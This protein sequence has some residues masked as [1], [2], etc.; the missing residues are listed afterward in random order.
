[1]SFGG[2]HLGRLREVWEAH[3][4][5]VRLAA[6]AIVVQRQ[7][8][9][10]EPRLAQQ[11]AQLARRLVH[12]DAPDL[13]REPDVVRAAVVAGEVRAD[14]VAQVHALADV[15]RQL[16]H[17]VEAV[18][19]GPFGQ[20]LERVGSELRRKARRLEEPAHRGRDLLDVALAV[21]RLHEAPD[22]ARVA[23]RGMAAGSRGGGR[24]DRF[25][26]PVPRDHRVQ[27]VPHRFG[28]EAARQA[29][30]AQHVRAEGDL[31]AAE[32]VLEE[33]VVEAR[34]VGDEELALEPLQHVARDLG[35]G[36][37]AAH[38]RVGDAGEDLDVLG[39]GALGIHQ[40]G[41]FVHELAAGHAH[42]A[43]LGDAIARRRR[44]GGLQVDERDGGCEH[45]AARARAARRHGA[46]PKRSMRKSTI[47]ATRGE[48][49]RPCG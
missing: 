19:A 29:H 30:G 43:D 9:L 36:G 13:A 6:Q 37:R 49:W 28:I 4:A 44:A 22:R 18:D 23:E 14:A 3:E 12:L 2:E 45:Q 20:S 34:V 47:A 27:P 5:R 35:E 42:D 46:P 10:H 26:Q 8:L 25:L 40:R 33:P 38:H 21:D 17:A 31:E 39:N 15:D 1:M 48:R 11:R 16:V 41:P 24:S 32:F 7:E